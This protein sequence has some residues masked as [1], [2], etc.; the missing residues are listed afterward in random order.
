MNITD[1]ILGTKLLVAQIEA[2]KLKATE[3]EL[4]KV[5]S[6]I[7]TFKQTFPMGGERIEVN[8]VLV[9]TLNSPKCLTVLDESGLE[10]FLQ[11]HGKSLSDYQ[12]KKLGKSGWSWVAA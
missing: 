6:D 5:E 9:A 1:K 10:N 4:K 8:G 7:E 3:R 2:S 11:K 12:S